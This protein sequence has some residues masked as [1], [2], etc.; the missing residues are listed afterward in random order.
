MFESKSQ[1]NTQRKI[2]MVGCISKVIRA[3]FES[4]SQP[5]MM[6][7][8][9]LPCCISKVIRAMFESKSQRRNYENEDYIVVYQR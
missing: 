1:L 4:K 5:D 6:L 8:I 9:A 3:M 7:P 2:R